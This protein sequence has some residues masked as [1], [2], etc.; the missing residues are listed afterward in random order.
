MSGLT[1]GDIEKRGARFSKQS[2]IEIKSAMDKIEEGVKAML[3]LLEEGS[4]Q[5]ADGDGTPAP[6][7]EKRADGAVDA[8]GIRDAMKEL[9]AWVQDLQGAIVDVAKGTGLVPKDAGEK[10]PAAAAGDTGQNG[11]APLTLVD[12]AKVVRS[13]I[14]KARRPVYKSLGG[15]PPEGEGSEAEGSEAETALRKRLDAL[16]PRERLGALNRIMFGVR[17]E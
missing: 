11:D 9:V 1:L 13:E 8:T 7:V 5:K 14:A 2:Q 12:V 15:S 6:A 16:P 3:A 4:T 10:A 17:V